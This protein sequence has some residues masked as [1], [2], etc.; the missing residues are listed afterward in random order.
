MV[1]AVESCSI[2]MIKEPSRRCYAAK[3]LIVKMNLDM[4]YELT[5]SKVRSVTYEGIIE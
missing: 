1:G 2:V 5:V 3:G 4:R